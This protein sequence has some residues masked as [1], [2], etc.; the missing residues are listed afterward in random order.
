MSLRIV[1]RSADETIGRGA[2][3]ARTLRPGDV[4]GLIGPLG[5]GKTQFIKGVC[6]GLGVQ[7]DVLSPTFV[8]M[9][10]YEATSGAVV[11]NHFDFYRIRR[12]EELDEIG[13]RDLIGGSAISLVEW[14]DSFPE[15]LPG[16]ALTVRLDYGED[17]DTRA[18]QLPADHVVKA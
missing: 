7:S 13:F 14:A 17:P 2:A 10:R 15:A 8:L 5:A 6:A 18:I 1:T 12:S 16:H 4:V 3:F 9:H 11:V